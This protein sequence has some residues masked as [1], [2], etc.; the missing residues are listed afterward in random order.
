MIWRQID[1]FGDTFYYEKYFNQ[2]LI[3][4]T[5]YKQFE[6]SYILFIENENFQ[7]SFALFKNKY[8]PNARYNNVYMVISHDKATY[9]FDKNVLEIQS[10]IDQFMDKINNL[11]AFI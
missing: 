9:H 2:I 5:E 4:H 6:T 11:K 10:N 1:K 7:K 8:Y 3:R